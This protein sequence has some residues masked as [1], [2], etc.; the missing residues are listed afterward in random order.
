MR[1]T[2][3]PV[4]SIN[5]DSQI[6]EAVKVLAF[7][8]QTSLSKSSV[9]DFPVD[10]FTFSFWVKTDS[11]ATGDM[12]FSY[13]AGDSAR[14]LWVKNSANLE[15]GFGGSSTGATDVAVNDNYWHHL[16]CT[17]FPADQTHY[18]VQVYKDGVL[19]F[20]N[21]RALSHSQGTVIETG[22]KLGIGHGT[23]TELN[24]TGMVSDFRLW[25]A[26]RK[27]KQIMTDMQVRM[28]HDPALVLYWRLESQAT[29]GDIV[30]GAFV[31]STLR[32]RTQQLTTAWTEISGAIYNLEVT[33]VDDDFSF[34]KEKISGLQQAVT[35][36][37]INRQYR[38]RVKAVVGETPGDWSEI[39]TARVLNLQKTF[40][41]I[42]L[43]DA[44]SVQAV[45]VP[46]DQAESYTIVQK[47]ER[48]G[49]TQ[50]FNRT[51]AVFPLT[52]LAGETDPYTFR[53]QAFSQGSTGTYSDV[54]SFAAP[55]MVFTCQKDASGLSL[56]AAWTPVPGANHYY[57][58]IYKGSLA[59]PPVYELF[60]DQGR[61]SVQITALDLQEN[62]IYIARVRGIGPGRVGEWCEARQI[63][64][65]ILAAPEPSFMY[66]AGSGQVRLQWADV[67][68]RQQKDA[69]LAVVYNVYFYKNNAAEPFDRQTATD[70]FFPIAGTILADNS[71][72]AVKVQATAAGSYGSWSAAG[73]V[74]APVVT[75]ARYDY[76]TGSITVQYSVI[77]DSQGYLEVFKNQGTIPDY[78]AFSDKARSITYTPAKVADNDVY[79][80]QVRAMAAGYI[81]KYSE[82]N[83]SVTIAQLIGP[84]ITSATGSAASHSITAA[85][86]FNDSGSSGVTYNLELWNSNCTQRLLQS[87]AAAKTHT[88]QDAGVITDKNV[89]N[90]RV[91]AVRGASLGRWSGFSAVAVNALTPVRDIGLRSDDQANITVGYSSSESGATYQVKIFIDG[92]E[93]K[94]RESSDMSVVFSQGDT[95]V[96][97]GNSYDVKVRI[98]TKKGPETSTTAEKS[99]RLKIEA[100]QPPDPKPP[101]GGDPINLVT[102]SYAYSHCDLEV[103]CLE[104]L[105]FITYYQTDIPLPGESGYYDGKPLGNRWNHSYNTRIVITADKKQL[106]VIWGD[107]S[108]DTYRVPD[109][110]TGSYPAL[111]ARR[112]YSLAFGSDRC[113]TLTVKN[114][115][116]YRFSQDGRLTSIT[117]PA[118]NVA[119]LTYTGNRLGRI[120]LDATHYLALDYTGSGLLKTISDHAARA[121]TYEYQNDNLVSVTN[122][123]GKK[124]T[125]TYTGKSLVKTIIDEN[126]H[127]IIQNTYDGDNRVVFQKDARAVAEGADYGVAIRYSAIKENNLD[128]VV[129]D[130]TDRSGCAARYKSYRVSNNLKE[131]TWQLGHGK[132]RKVSKTYDAFSNL[133][134]ETIYEGLEAEYAGGKGNKTTYTYDDNDNLLT[135]RDPLGQVTSFA[136]DGNNNLIKEV[137]SLGNTT[138]YEYDGNLLKKI[139]DPLQREMGIT[140][141]NTGLKGLIGSITGLAG[142]TF[143]FKYANGYLQEVV[144]PL[145]EKRTFEN[146]ALGRVLL[147]TVTDARGNTLQKIKCD[148]HADGSCRKR[149]VMLN[150]QPE[151]EAYT[152]S[153]SYDQVG[154]LSSETDAAGNIMNYRYD[155]NDLL[156]KIIYPASGQMTRETNY[157]YDK[158]DHLQQITHSGDVLRQYRYDAFNRLLQFTDANRNLYTT[159]YEQDYLPDNTY[160]TR[161]V[162]AFPLTE[163]GQAACTE[164]RAYDPAGRLIAVKNRSNQQTALSYG[165]EE[166]S[167]GG[168]FNRV[169]TWTLPLLDGQASGYTIVRKYDPAGRLIYFKNEAGS[170]TSLAYTV[171][172]DPVIA[173]K[174]EVTTETNCLG[175]QKIT[176]RDALGR[177][178]S[179]REGRD[180]LWKELRYQYDALGRIISAGENKQEGF[181]Y[182]NYIYSYDRTTKHML[183]TQGRPG[184][185]QNVTVRRYNGLD[186]LV[187]ETDPVNKTTYRTYTPWG[188]VGSCT[189][190]RGQ[191][192]AY[193]YDAAGRFTGM[194][195]PGS[196]GTVAHL[197]DGNGNR[198]ETLL[199]GASRIKR[200][201]D[202]WNRMTSR[203][204]GGGAKIQYHFTP[205]DRVDRLTYSDNKQVRYA[206]DSLGR[207][208]GVTDWNNR[209][210]LYQY[211]PAGRVRQISYPNSCKATLDFDAAGRL[212]GLAHKKDDTIIA[213]AQYNLDAL[214]NKTACQAVHPISPGPLSQPFNAAYN[215]GNQLQTFNGQQLEYDDD[216]NLVTLPGSQGT[217]AVAYD[218][219]NRVSAVDNDSCLYDE[220]GLRSSLT[221]NGVTRKFVYD[222]NGFSSPLLNL[223][224][225]NT[226]ATGVII[227]DG[228]SGA[229][230]LLQ[231]PG[232]LLDSLDRLLE[233]RDEEGRIL[234]RY[235]Y[236]NGLISQE[237]NDGAYRVY[238]FDPR[239]SVVAL[240]D[241]QG[242]ITDRYAYDAWGNLS[243]FQGSSFNPFLYNGIYGVYHDGNGLTYMRA[244]SYAP[245][246]GRFLQKDPLPGSLFSPQSL[247]RYAFVRGNPVRLIDPLGLFWKDV[248]IGFGIGAAIG[249][250]I[251]LFTGAAG[252]GGAAVGG[253]VGGAIGGVVAGPLGA[254]AGGVVGGGIGANANAAF[255]WL[256]RVARSVRNFFR[257]WRHTREGYELVNLHLD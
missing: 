153:Y 156:S 223:P 212:T 171:Q 100:P 109:S 101:K 197:L 52:D 170:E 190:G 137:D 69:G 7:N 146:D 36:Y 253:A 27:D 172:N 166:S 68:T 16:A 85:W 179:V 114:Q 133:L 110:I 21:V 25:N 255:N 246:L 202:P 88:F 157:Q 60:T 174:Q 232:S 151:S 248:A 23:G 80:P 231:P 176:V 229:P 194:L 12:L 180:E 40:P 128:M 33:G 241:E 66:D 186:Q 79:N 239:G 142:N 165:K 199:N 116:A 201:F 168:V 37:S 89:Y 243:N 75:Q 144:S 219:C 240:T 200:T 104:P 218:W 30:N 224:E 184:D 34:A 183:V 74:D 15:I 124:R 173:A 86:I 76:S 178:V 169:V 162:T 250:G 148:Y 50:T 159:D 154:N 108:L 135:V 189:N 65:H 56:H 1:D 127:T 81:S 45:W 126:G 213:S 211:D 256:T 14:R 205:G 132:I 94:T 161:E 234:Y 204:D 78:T 119:T 43:P 247:N 96:Q 103:P 87:P 18:G 164:A 226:N 230:A 238:A 70:L 54:V 38:A 152:T 141:D 245:R 67:R 91:Q 140:Y 191:A 214:G 167:A 13:D 182:A 254:A 130:Y 98:V 118:G 77:N 4:L 249:G 160:A 143:R 206:Y 58:Q 227:A 149:S 51:E 117:S 129:A 2:G 138:S 102:G 244:R 115:Y 242:I 47:N 228:F 17:V 220:D 106:G 217:A 59:T 147:D 46:V 177:I 105:Q 64:V 49:S 71:I 136:Y 107:Y 196:Q 181:V 257:N 158:S 145:G 72:Y 233:L 112:G 188:E 195:L 62:D 208:S 122:V 113:F 22:G 210:T 53:V 61:S 55:P 6:G 175:M 123:M 41:E 31:D 185:D 29:S 120:Q 139:T 10:G 203:Q 111:N 121:V 32:F 3:K 93:K 35:G 216:G 63:A 221:I 57:L 251:G 97:T 84:L 222:V 131:G 39:K 125:F 44:H 237:G 26:V 252:G 209:A 163:P 198:M 207:L 11:T 20:A 187:Q 95:G 134:S 19:M 5:Y 42:S 73:Q 236:G 9:E 99:Q 83:P 192:V 48:T 90:V 28:D 82:N 92:T 225:N 150:D 193:H 235:V 24:F 215:G 155:P 8:G